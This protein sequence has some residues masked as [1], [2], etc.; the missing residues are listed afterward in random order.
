MQNG[1]LLFTG[2]NAIQFTE[3]TDSHPVINIFKGNDIDQL[4]IMETGIR[5]DKRISGQWSTIWNITR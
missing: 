3:N 1:E 5:F 2:Y 4:I